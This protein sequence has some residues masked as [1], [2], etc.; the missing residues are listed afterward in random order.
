MTNDTSDIVGLVVVD[1]REVSLKSPNMEKEGLRRILD[2]LKDKNVKVKEICTDAHVQIKS[3]I[4]ECV[5][6]IC[7]L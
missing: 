1:K 7:Q 6:N 5:L 4:S 3:M 2:N